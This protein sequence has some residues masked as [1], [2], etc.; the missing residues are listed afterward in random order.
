[1]SQD[2]NCTNGK[3][4]R[5]GMQLIEWSKF[6]LKQNIEY[7]YSKG[8][9]FCRSIMQDCRCLPKY[10]CKLFRLRYIRLRTVAQVEAKTKEVLKTVAKG[11]LPHDNV[12]DELKSM[13]SRGPVFYGLTKVHKSTTPLDPVVSASGGPKKNILDF[14]REYL[15]SSS[16]L[17]LLSCWTLETSFPAQQSTSSQP[18]PEGAIFFSV[19]V[20]NL[21]GSIPIDEAIEAVKGKLERHGQDI[22][23]YGLTYDDICVLLD[24]CLNGNVFSFGNSYYRQKLGRA[25]GNRRWPP[26]FLTNLNNRLFRTLHSNQS[27]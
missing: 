16:H 25:M 14:S 21:H 26:F 12:V 10:A 24:Q 11:K 23:T 6:F 18:F 20:V 19:D 27:F 7:N 1:M 3:K 17:F 15:S 8:K 4:Y 22:D 9:I 13:H 5:T 2:R